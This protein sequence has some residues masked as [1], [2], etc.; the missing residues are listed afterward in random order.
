MPDTEGSSPLGRIGTRGRQCGVLTPA[1]GE[2]GCFALKVDRS[3]ERRQP[4]G[5][6]LVTAMLSI[7]SPSRRSAAVPS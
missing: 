1:R 3:G 2:L 4:P 7:S 5:I 6:S